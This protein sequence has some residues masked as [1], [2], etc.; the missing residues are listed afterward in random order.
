MPTK[1][2]KIAEAQAADYLHTLYRADIVVH[3]PALYAGGS[4]VF[5]KI[6][7]HFLCERRYQ[8]AL[9]LFDAYIYLAYKIVYLPLYRPN[10]YLRVEQAGRRIICS[11]ICP[12]L[13]RS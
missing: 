4:E 11:A 8:S 6:L 7:C 1:H 3:V 2:V 9:A 13:S 12:A 10:G 5:G